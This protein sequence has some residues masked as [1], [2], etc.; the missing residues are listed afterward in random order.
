MMWGYGTFMWGY[1]LLMMLGMLLGF[2]LV[3]VLAWAAIRWLSERTTPPTRDERS[4]PSDERSALE[5]LQQ[6]YARGEIDATTF[7]Q[8]RERLEASME[9]EHLPTR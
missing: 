3:V 1:G 7:E 6:R 9:R 4:V 5:I 2:V 8:M